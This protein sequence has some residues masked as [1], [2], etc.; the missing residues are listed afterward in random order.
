[1]AELPF[2]AEL[3]Y[4]KEGQFLRAKD[5][6]DLV[7]N[8]RSLQIEIASLRREF[9]DLTQGTPLP[10]LDFSPK[11]IYFSGD[12]YFLQYPWSVSCKSGLKDFKEYKVIPNDQCKL[13]VIDPS[14]VPCVEIRDDSLVPLHIGRSML[15]VNVPFQ[16][17]DS[18]FTV[19]VRYP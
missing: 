14:G 10:E 8:V 1:M 17:R 12:Q 5:L 19:E 3:P 2:F 18:I 11:V 7:E 9:G 6:N 13:E 15:K 4:F 16:T